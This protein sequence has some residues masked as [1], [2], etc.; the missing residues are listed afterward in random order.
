VWPAPADAE[1]TTTRIAKPPAL[2]IIECLMEIALRTM[3]GADLEFAL[4]QTVRE[5]WSTRRERLEVL[6]EHDPDGCLIAEVGGQPV[7]MTTGTAFVGSGWIGNVIVEP[8]W[9]GQGIGRRLVENALARFD[10]MG[11]ETVRLDGDPPGVPL[12]RSLGFVEE[13]ESSRAVGG[14]PWPAFGAGV[15]EHHGTLFPE[16]LRLDLRC[17]G[18][19][20]SRLLELMRATAEAVLVARGTDGFEGYAFLVPALDA[21]QLGPCVASSEAVAERLV[22][23]CLA[24]AGRRAV[25]VG[26]PGANL[27]AGRLFRDLA[28]HPVSGSLRMVRGKL[29]HAGEQALVYGIASGATG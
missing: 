12:Y 7:G 16:L 9:R 23:A 13:L 19:D 26:Y 11:I 4:R 29:A 28:F 15:E 14:G 18:D 24:R 21:V 1:M 3:T 20:R 8:G 22:R 17:F 2:S 5:G 10:R 27:A 6:L 25:I